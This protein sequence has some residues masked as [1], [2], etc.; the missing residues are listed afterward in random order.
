MKDLLDTMAALLAIHKTLDALNTP[1]A[2]DAKQ[3]IGM[4]ILNT[5]KE[6]LQ[7]SRFSDDIPESIQPK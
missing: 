2:N 4:A 6:I 7:N 5:S 1:G 3:I